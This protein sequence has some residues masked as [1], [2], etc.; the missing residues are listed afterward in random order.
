MSNS[1]ARGA[2]QTGRV[3]LGIATLGTTAWFNGGIKDFGL[4]NV[5][6]Y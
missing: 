1:F 3:L 5:L 4:T 6:K 2:T